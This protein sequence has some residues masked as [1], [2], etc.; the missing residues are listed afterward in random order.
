[1]S[2][3]DLPWLMMDIDRLSRHVRI[4]AGAAD[5]QLEGE[6]FTMQ[7]NPHFRKSN[8]FKCHYPIAILR[9]AKI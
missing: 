1:L 2:V 9:Y 8:S 4:I 7:D 3:L 5:Q 6:L